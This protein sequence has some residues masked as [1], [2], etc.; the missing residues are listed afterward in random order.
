VP[1][2]L[3]FTALSYCVTAAAGLPKLAAT[4]LIDVRP[5]AS[6]RPGPRVAMTGLSR[7]TPRSCPAATHVFERIDV[8]VFAF[9]KKTLSG[10]E[11]SMSDR[12]RSIGRSRGAGARLSPDQAV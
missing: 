7:S 8:H 11:G 12:H 5:P 9:Y 3:P 6:S 1:V 10:Y 4:Y 2:L